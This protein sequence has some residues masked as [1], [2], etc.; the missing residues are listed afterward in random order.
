MEYTSLVHILLRVKSMSMQHREKSTG[1]STDYL[2][3]YLPMD[4]LVDKRTMQFKNMFCALCEL[5]LD[6][7]LD[8]QY[9]QTKTGAHFAS[10][11]KHVNAT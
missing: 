4:I 1:Y 11:E 8:L 9:N 2:F 3:L 7:I 5:N 10:C 6:D